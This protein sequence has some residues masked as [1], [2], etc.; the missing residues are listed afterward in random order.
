M[1]EAN[2]SITTIEGPSKQQVARATGIAVLV[3]AIIFFTVV[4]PASME[5]IHCTPGRRWG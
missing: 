4:L 1:S 3:A 2:T 5:K